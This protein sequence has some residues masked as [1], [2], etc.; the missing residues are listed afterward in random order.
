M[1]LPQLSPNEEVLAAVATDREVRL[2]SEGFLAIVGIPAALMMV[3]LIGR[4]TSET[5]PLQG[6][7]WDSYVRMVL[8]LAP[9]VI[10]ASF[11]RRDRYLV[12][13]HRIG[14]VTPDAQF[15]AIPLGEVTS[16]S[17]F[18]GTVT[19]KSATRTLRMAHLREAV[20]LET[21]LRERIK[22]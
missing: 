10:I 7:D 19:V 4:D 5:P 2:L 8:S 11:R 13:T 20:A 14:E 18:L 6:L 16:I 12:T 21:L 22:G 1:T 3:I 9:A 15:S 17:R